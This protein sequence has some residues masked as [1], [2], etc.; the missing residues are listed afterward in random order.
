M[1][2][3]ELGEGSYK[4]NPRMAD[5]FPLLV[6]HYITKMKRAPVDNFYPVKSRLAAGRREPHLTG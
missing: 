3:N 5:Y 4:N 6:Y 2:K 1:T